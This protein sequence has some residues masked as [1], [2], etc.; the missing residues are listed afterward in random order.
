MAPRTPD[1]PADVVELLAAFDRAEVHCLVIG[2]YAVGYEFSHGLSASLVGDTAGRASVGLKSLQI[3]G[4]QLMPLSGFHGHSIVDR[5]P[6]HAE[7][8]NQNINSQA[9][10]AANLARDQLDLLEHY[11]AV[12]MLCATQAVE[13]RAHLVAGTY[14]ARSVLSPA[15]RDLYVR[16][17]TAATG[18]P[19]ASR[20]LLWSDLD[21]LLQPK[22]EGLLA[23]IARR[24]PVFDA[25]SE[26]VQGL[27]GRHMPRAGV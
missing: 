25:L 3:V 22:V 8:Y 20:P 24:G 10:N 11:L 14:D 4:N 2:G 6:T 13:L 9:M 18:P 26:V 17:R 1:L 15:T 16:A 23:D 7:Q 12:A 19:Q 5:Y 27:H 21:E